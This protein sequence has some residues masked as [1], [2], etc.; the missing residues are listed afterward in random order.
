M[1]VWS[2]GGK[3]LGG[4]IPPPPPPPAW[5]GFNTSVYHYSFMKEST[6]DLVEKPIPWSLPKHIIMIFLK[7]K[8]WKTKLTSWTCP[9]Y[10]R[11][12]VNSQSIFPWPSYHKLF[13][14][15]TLYQGRGLVI[16]TLQ[17]SSF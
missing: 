7:F 9:D 11:L 17:A 6:N 2:Y 8:S 12:I 16:A 15:H 14:T 10:G 5:I 1:A 13:P 4:R 3:T